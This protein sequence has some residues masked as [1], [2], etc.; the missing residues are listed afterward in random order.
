METF[1]TASKRDGKA[2]EA[3]QVSPDGKDYSRGDRI[4]KD[5][6]WS[7]GDVID[8]AKNIEGARNEARPRG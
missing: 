3:T 7:A 8:N 5:R 4:R 2:R 6:Y 1:G